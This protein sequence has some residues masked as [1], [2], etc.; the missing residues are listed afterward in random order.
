MRRWWPWPRRPTVAA[1]GRSPPTAASSPSATPGSTARRAASTSMRRWWAWR[2]RPT[3]VAT[4]RSPPTA[5]S[6]PSATPG[7][8]ARRAASTSM[9]RSWAWPRRPTVAGYWEVASDG[10]IFTFGDA[11]FYGST[12]GQHLNAPVVAMAATPDGRGLLAGGLRRRDLHLRRRRVLRL[13]GRPAPQRAGG[14]PWRRRPTAGATGRSP[15]TAA[16]SPSA[17][18][19]S[20]ARR[21]ASTS[22]RRWWPW[23][24]RPTARV[25]GGRLRRWD[26][27]VRRRRVLRLDGRP[28]TAQGAEDRPL[29]GL[30]GHGGRSGLQLPGRCVRRLRSGADIRRSCRLRFPD[31]YGFGRG[32]LPTDGGGPRVQR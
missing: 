28:S 17:T 7:S 32:L 25:L 8:T 20:T 14:R 6:S 11:G 26:L 23:P 22:M 12:G 30:T 19:G 10:G 13:D 29:R 4:G 16:S 24:R 21:A 31:D 2:R 27:P 9:R 5:A 1:I 18:P 3:V 15:P